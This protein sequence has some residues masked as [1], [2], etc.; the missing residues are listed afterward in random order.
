MDASEF[1]KSDL[2]E[3]LG[4]EIRTP[5]MVGSM[6]LIMRAVFAVSCPTIAV[7]GYLGGEPGAVSESELKLD[8]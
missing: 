3:P 4:P 7:K 8:S 2:P 5:P 1:T 6:A